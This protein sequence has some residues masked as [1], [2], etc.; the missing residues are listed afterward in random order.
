M[1]RT[2][3]GALIDGRKYDTHTG[4]LWENVFHHSGAR[5]SPVYVTRVK[6]LFKRFKPHEN[7]VIVVGGQDL[8]NLPRQIVVVDLSQR[9]D[10]L[11]TLVWRT[12]T[13]VVKECVCV[14]GGEPS[15]LWK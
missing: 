12:M 10:I 5:E 3:A 13:V 15:Y 1:S 11:L 7:T 14:W 9:L 2:S 4:W 8:F 6:F